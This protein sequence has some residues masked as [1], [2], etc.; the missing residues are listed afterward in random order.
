MTMG[1]IYFECN[2]FSS[3]F[4]SMN[5]QTIYNEFQK[6]DFNSSKNSKWYDILGSRA[7]HTM[8]KPFEWG[9]IMAL[10]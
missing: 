7:P 6:L 2:D 4:S 8:Y 10:D 9:L 5:I 3:S 1:S